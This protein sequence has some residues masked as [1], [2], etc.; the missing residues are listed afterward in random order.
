[1]PSATSASQ[2]Q[3]NPASLY[4]GPSGW[5][6]P[7]WE[8]IVYPQPAPRGFDALAYMSR[9]FNALEVNTSFYRPCQARMTQ[10]WARRIRDPARFRFVFKLHQ[11]FTHQRQEPYAHGDVERFKQGLVPVAE[12]GLLGCILMQFPWSFRCTESA[13]GWLQRLRDDFGE[14]PL[15]V[16]VRHASWDRPDARERLGTMGLS[17]CT[18]DQPRLPNCLTPAAHV[19]GPIGYVR[20]HGRRAQTWFAEG[21]ESHERYDYLYGEDELRDLAGLIRD[22]AARSKVVFVFANNHY[23]GQGPANALQLRALLSDGKVPVPEVML[24]HFPFLKRIAK[25]PEHPH[26]GPQTTLFD[27]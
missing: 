23:R 24:T 17:L 21:I 14:F 3:R 20:L 16:E 11:R 12:A 6:Y 15:A 7:D 26:D 1:M 9:Y 8:G 18:I 5:S 13:F 4:I 22:V 10:S 25:P 2:S 19:T 27:L